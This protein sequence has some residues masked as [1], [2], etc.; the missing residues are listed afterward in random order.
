MSFFHQYFDVIQFL[1]CH[2]RITQSV[3]Q[4]CQTN[5]D[6]STCLRILSKLIYKINKISI[7]FL[8]NLNNSL[9]LLLKL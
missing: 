2:F 6:H 1:S 3:P 5:L 7:K 4:F 9:Y 8:K